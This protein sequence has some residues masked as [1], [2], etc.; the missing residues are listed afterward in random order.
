MLAAG[1]IQ[2]DAADRRVYLL[3]R[4]ENLQMLMFVDL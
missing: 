1:V 4:S 3:L 2:S